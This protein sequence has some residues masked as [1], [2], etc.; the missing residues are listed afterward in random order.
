[1]PENSR[2]TPGALTRRAS[3]IGGLALAGGGALIGAKPVR[4]APSKGGL[5]RLATH[6]QSTNDT[7]DP[8]K[9][10]YGNDY[11]RG[12]CVYNSLTYLD[13]QGQA[14]PELAESFEPNDTATRWV[15]KIRKGVTYQDG[16]PLSMDDI[17][18]SIMRHK[19]PKLASSAKP[20]VANIKEVKADGPDTIIV[21]LNGPDV[22][23]PIMIGTFQFMVVKN[24]TT[25]FSNPVG[26]GPFKMKSFTPGVGTSFTRNPNYWKEGRPYVDEVEMFH[27][28]DPV[29]RANALLSGDA[30][31]VTELKGTAIEQVSTS[32]NAAVFTTPCPRYTSIQAAVDR[33]PSNNPDLGLALTYLIDRKRLLDTVLKGQGV[34]GN[35]HPIMPTSQLY[36]HDLPQRTLDL[37]RAKY[38]FGKSGFGTSTLEIHV[39]DAA[40]FSADIGQLLQREAS[41]IGLTIELK[42]DPADSYWNAVAGQRPYTSITFNPRPTYNML[43]NLAYRSGAAWN[44][45]H[46]NDPS[47]DKLIDDARS[48]PDKTQRLQVYA[49]IQKKI[50]DSGSMTLPC[51]EN[52]VDGISK[53][54]KGLVPV[55][56]GN[57]AGF[58]FADRVWLET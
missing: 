47:L 17:V 1:M 15:F 10:I 36:D 8:A 27:V 20:L 3:L 11:I 4:A 37:D 13:E 49:D 6:S 43:L 51:F 57:L 58:N 54:V 25:D 18:F 42:R 33:A 56:V 14:N 35:D 7:F 24:G 5:L 52:Y 28:L 26:T 53:K 23:L 46:I 16:A 38:H 39:S 29:A 40:P 19:D 21:D 32:A 41:R 31:M 34:I 22:D 55:P 50:Y 2:R 30:Q 44:F 12:T 45:S 9:Y 48:T